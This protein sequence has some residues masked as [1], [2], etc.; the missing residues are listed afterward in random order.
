MVLLEK[1]HL[2]TYREMAK[3]AT[4]KTINKVKPSQSIYMASIKFFGQNYIG[5]GYS[6]AEAVEKIKVP[7]VKPTKGVLVIETKGRKQEKI[8][9]PVLVHR[10]FSQSPLTREIAIRNVV[11]MFNL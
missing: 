4:K 5:E 9:S 11:N 10:M 3:K 7:N 2:S 8:I 1:L 6:L